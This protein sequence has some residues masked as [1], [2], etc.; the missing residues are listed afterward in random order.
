[1]TTQGEIVRQSD[2]LNRIVIDRSTMEELGSIDVLWMHPP[3]HRVLGFICK[4][5]FL[6]T[7]KTAF[8]LAQIKTLGTNSI[9]VNARP[10]ET[11]SEQVRKLESLIGCEVWR[12]DGDKNGK[13][14]DCLFN[15]KTGAITQYLFVSHGW[16]GI[17]SD[18]Y[19]LPPRQILSFGNKRVLVSVAE[20]L[21]VYRPGIRQKLSKAGYSLQQEYEQATQELRSLA[22]QAQA[23][24]TEAKERAQALVEQAKQKVQTLNEQLKEETEE[25]SQSLV[26]QVK[27]RAQVI[28]EQVKEKLVSAPPS[29]AQNSHSKEVDDSGTLED[30][31]EP[32]I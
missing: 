25:K 21:D 3:V 17:A 7:K 22:K 20:N 6:G 19:L 10:V 1:M 16:G 15:L 30:D 5:G 27:E 11:D 26:E 14:I 31:D 4:S 2:L 9:L 12:D 32:W 24:T 28:S 8:N 18:I 13:I 23:A 29:T